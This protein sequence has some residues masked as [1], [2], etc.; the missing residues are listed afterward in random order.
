VSR[1]RLEIKCAYEYID[2][3]LVEVEAGRDQIFS[4]APAE[5]YTQ[6]PAPIHSGIF[7]LEY[8][9]QEVWRAQRMSSAPSKCP[10]T[11]SA[12][13]RKKGGREPRLV[14]RT[15]FGYSKSDPP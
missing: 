3:S 12:T 10:Y 11:C 2:D 5:M 4:S 9:R 6:R 15:V 7:V 8:S 1:N 14:S 13:L